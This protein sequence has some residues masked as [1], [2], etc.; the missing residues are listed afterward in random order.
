MKPQGD[1]PQTSA[2]SDKGEGISGAICDMAAS[3]LS[4]STTRRRLWPPSATGNAVEGRTFVIGREHG[5]RTGF[6]A[7]SVGLIQNGY[8]LEGPALS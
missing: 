8:G 5:R 3:P 2:G 6:G 4:T 7:A 1:M